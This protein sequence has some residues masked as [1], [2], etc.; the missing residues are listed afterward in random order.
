MYSIIALESTSEKIARGASRAEQQLTAA[1]TAAGRGL[2]ALLLCRQIADVAH[3]QA[4]NQHALIM[5]FGLR[6]MTEG[7]LL[8]FSHCSFLTE[9][10]PPLV[11]LLGV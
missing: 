8:L 4:G 2:R 9:T 10:P 11:F 5:L 1:K 3:A 7:T 6:Q